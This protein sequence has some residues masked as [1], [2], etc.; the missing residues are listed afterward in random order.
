MPIRL[1]GKTAAEHIYHNITT[2]INHLLKNNIVP[3]LTVIQV[4]DK[5]DSTTYV[6]MKAKMCEKYKINSNVIRLPE[7]INESELIEIINSHNND[8]SVHGI[9]IQLP[10]PKHICEDNIL[11]TVHINKDVD[12][13]NIQNVGKL[14][15]NAK[16]KFVPCT[17]DGCIEMLKYYNI[18]VAGKHA[19]VI[20]RSRIVGLPLA[21][22]LLRE[23]ATVSIC[24]SKTQ[25]IQ[26]ITK[27]A[28]LIFAA[29]GKA[30][31]IDNT[32]VKE[33]AIIIDIGINPVPDETKKSG[34]RLVG[35]V[36]YDDVKDKVHAISPVPG[37]VGPMT[38]AM[39]LKHTVDAA[40]Q[41]SL[42]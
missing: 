29:C 42:L 32:M 20:G 7:T 19:V 16:P 23:N 5:K 30:N 12:G 6:N 22:L 9:L 34:Y 33:N 28:D 17:P 10:L 37:G 31:F 15:I 1:C 4:G 11:N 14:S 13:F 39:L 27:S 38:I 18:D 36:N 26:S 24:H 40:E 25:N 8:N 21:H 35:D 2:K 41:H 3:G